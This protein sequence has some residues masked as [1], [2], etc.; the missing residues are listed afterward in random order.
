MVM[1]HKADVLMKLR[2]KPCQ[3]TLSSFFIIPLGVSLDTT[4][5]RYPRECIVLI[6][7]ANNACDPTKKWQHRCEWIVCAK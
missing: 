6:I 7:I 4:H 5:A 2:E 3:E 1:Q